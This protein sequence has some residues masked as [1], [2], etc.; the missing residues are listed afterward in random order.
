MFATFFQT[1]TGA[2]MAFRELR[3]SG[4][5]ISRSMSFRR[6]RYG[7]PVHHEQSATL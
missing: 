2:E 5:V 6:Q 4:R 3:R 7:C 1:I